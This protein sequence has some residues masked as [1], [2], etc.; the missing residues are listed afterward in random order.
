MQTEIIILAIIGFIL[1]L[2]ALSIEKKFK[3]EAY[4]PACDINDKIS[5]TKALTS[6]YAKIF[7]IKN[8]LLGIFFYTLI[9]ILAIISQI[10][11]IFYLSIISVLGSIYLAYIS[12]FKLKTICI[13]CTSIYLVNILLLIISY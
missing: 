4:K 8:S 6:P 3:K 10:Q 1:S 2:Y 13:I 12:Y 5:C 11:T 9:I 7:K